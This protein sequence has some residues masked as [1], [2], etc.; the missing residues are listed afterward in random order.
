M[1]T[2]SSGINNVLLCGIFRD[3]TNYSFATVGGLVYL[4]TT[5]GTLTQ[6]QPSATDNVIQV[7]GIALATHILQVMP[8]LNYITHT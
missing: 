6:T 3:D 1:V 4:A 7:V 2:A 5:V 8:N